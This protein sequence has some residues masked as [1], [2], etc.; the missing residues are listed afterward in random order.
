VDAVSQQAFA[1]ALR[2]FVDGGGT[3]LLVAHEL[4]PLHPLVS[5]AVVIH[6]GVVAHDGAVP[7]PI[8]HHA[9]PGHDHVHPHA[10]Q[11]HQGMW[12]H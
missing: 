11:E 10:P 2:S 9:D 5:R 3:A 12:P 4:G 6:H 8:G 1:G 7:E